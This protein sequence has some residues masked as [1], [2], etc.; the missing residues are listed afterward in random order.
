MGIDESRSKNRSLSR[1]KNRRTSF[2]SLLC[3]QLE[4]REVMAGAIFTPGTDSNYMD[5][6]QS[7]IENFAQQQL[8]GGGNQINL[9]GN[10]WVN[11]TGGAS[12]NDGDPATITWSIVPDGTQVYNSTNGNLGSS[13]FVAFMDGIYGSA[14]GPI[15]SRPW[16]NLVKRGYDNWGANSGLNFIYEPKDD[17]APSIASSRGVL[18]VRGDIRVGGLAVDGNSGIL[19]YA[20]PPY[21]SGNNGI[22]GDI[23]FD[24]NDNFYS[25]NSDGPTGENRAFI[26]VMMHEAGHGVGLGHVL[27]TD[28]TKLME[29]FVSLA[30]Y[31]AQL[32]DIIATQTLYGDNFENNDGNGQASNLGLVGNGVQQFDNLSIDKSEDTDVY[33][34]TVGAA[35]VRRITMIP[36]GKQYQVQPEGGAL[37]TENT[38]VYRNLSF[39]IERL[40]GEV[41]A[42]SDLNP[43]GVPEVINSPSLTAGT[44]YLRVFAKNA[45]ETQMYSLK[46]EADAK[47]SVGPTLI[48]VQPN[49]SEL[50]ENGVVRSIAP[51]ELTFRFDDAQIIDPSTVSGIRVSRAGG[52]GSFSLPS[53]STDFGTNGRV[54]V[55][56]TAKNASDTL[57]INVTRADL[58]AGAPPKITI[59]GNVISLQLNSR[60]GSTVSAQQL[61]DLINAP[62]SPV[63]TK[64]SA[65]INGG[66]PATQLGAADPTTYSPILLQQSNDIIVS[67]GAV[68]VGDSPN[69]NEVT[70]RFAENLPD[71]VYR[72][73]VFGFDDSSR[74][75]TGLRNTSGDLFLPND[76]NTRQDTIEFRLDLGSKVTAVVPQPVVRNTFGVLEQKRDTIVV[77]FDNEKLFVENDASGNPTAGS[78]ENPD[79]YQ[80]LYTADT[81]R[82]TDDITFKPE[83]VTYNASANTATLRFSQD[84]DTLP[85]PFIPSSTFRLRVGTRE[86]T[87]IQ[88]VRSEASASAISDLNTNGLAKVRFQAKT[89]GEAGSGLQVAFVNSNSGGVPTV[90]SVGGIVTVDIGSSSATVGAVVDA[91]QKSTV[92]SPLMSVTLEPGTNP[93]TVVGDRVINYSPVT[94]YGLGSSFSTAADLGTIGSSAVPLTSVLLTSSID[95]EV[96]TLDLIGANNDPGSRKV[97][98]AFENYI[99]PAFTGDNFNGIRTIYYNFQDGY[100][101]VGGVT[102]SNAVTE[103]QKARIREAFSI[104]A[105]NIG[106]QFVE[107]PNSGLTMALGSLNALPSP[108]GLRVENAAS[109]FWGVRIDPTY[110]NSLAVFS[111][112][113]QWDDNYGENM[114]RAAM[115]SIGL[116][117]GLARAGDADPSTLMKFDSNFIN[118]TAGSDRNFE[119][120]F[121]GNLDTMRAQYLH[122]PESSDIDLYR[123]DVDFGTNGENRQGAL[124][125]ESFAE[126]ASSSSPL[127]TRLALFKQTQ[128]TAVSNLGAGGGVEVLFTA[129][130]PGKEG[131]NLQVF[132]TRSNRGVGA[133]PIINTFPNAITIDLNSSIGSETTLNELL[134][135]LDNDPAAR[136][137]VKVTLNKGDRAAVIG[138]RDITYSPITLFGGNVELIAQ[139]DDYFS[140]DSLIRMNLD[141][142]V[143]YIGVSASGNDKYD[144]S[145]PGTGN[146]GRTQGRYD[147]RLTFRA[148]TDG[149]DSIRDVSNGSG[150]PG[151]SLDGDGDG[152][153]G[154]VYNFWFETRPLDR[155]LRFNADGTAPIDGR[156]VTVTGGNGVVR[157]FEFSTDATV[158]IGNTAVRYTA[159]STAGDLALALAAAI[160]SRTELGVSATANGARITLKG[161]RLVQLSSGLTAIDISGKTIFVD[162]SA[163]P[164]ADGSLAKPFNN[165]AGSGVANA[166][167]A[168]LPGDIVRIVGN[169]G[170]DGKIETAN[171][172]F[173]YEV[174]YGVLAGSILADGA[175]MDVPKGVS[176]MVD[177]GAVF[178]MRRS[179]VGIGSSTLGVDRS[180]GAL[181][182]L[183]TP[184]LLDRNGNA[185]R[186]ANG[187]SVS[188]NVFFTSWLDESIGFDNY[189]PTT[190]PAAGDWGGLLFKRDLDK[191]AGRFD[192]EDEGIFRQYVNYAD[193]QYGGSSAVVIDSVQQS[194]NSIQITEMRPTLTFNRISNGA[195]SAISA[196]PDSFEE[197][198]FSDLRYQRKGSFTPDYDRIGPDIHDNTLV[199]NS[200]NG[201]FIKVSTPAGGEL[202]QLTVPGRFNDTDI[203]H[204]I[205]ENIIVQGNPGGAQL[206]A[207]VVSSNLI[208]LAPTLG[209]TFLPGSYSYKLTFVDK[210]GYETPPSNATQSI[211]L[212]PGQTAIRLI[213]LP[214][215]T[216]EYVSRRLYRADSVGGPYRLVAELDSST[217]SYQDR[218]TVLADALD[219]YA[220]LLR[221]R[222]NVSGIT[223]TPTSGGSLAAAAYT[224]RIVMID[225]M[226]R[227]GLASNTTAIATSTAT[228]RSL[229]LNNLPA[230]QAGYAGRRIYRSASGGAGT[231]SLIAEIRDPAINSYLDNGTTTLTGTL[232]VESSGNIRPRLDASLSIDPGS[233]IKIEGARIEFGQSTQLLAEGTDGNRIVFT[234]KQDDR[235]GAG[236]TFDT[237]NNGLRGSLDAKARD[238]SGIYASPG[239][240]ISLDNTVVAYAGGI[241]RLEGTFKAFS[242]LE[243]QQADARV[244]NSVFENNGNG[245]GGQGPIDRL[246]RPANENYPFG[247]N[248]S[249]GAT[250]FI[251]GTQ[252]IFVNNTFQNNVGTALTIDANSMD[253]ELRGDI[254][255][256][257]GEVDRIKNLDANRG[258]L[259]RG[260]RLYNNSINGLEVRADASTNNR[261]E[262]ALAVRDLQRN[263]LTTESVWDDT[264]MVHVL[265]D[266]ITVGNLQSVGGLR[267]QSSVNESL[268]IKMEGQGSN[269][270]QERGTGFTATGRF[271]GIGDRVGGT[272]TVMGMPGFPVVLTS[273]RDDSVGAG[274]Q[275]DGR[276][277]TD[278]N[279]DGIASI[280]RA[281]DWRSMLFDSFSNDRNVQTVLELEQADVIA[282][283]LNDSVLSAQFMGTMAPNA[284]TSDENLRLGFVVHGVLSE[285][286]DQDLFSFVA[287]AGTEVWFD[288]D[289]TEITLD[290]VIEILNANGDL[291]ARSDDS[292][293]EQLNPSLIYRDP[294]LD[295]D[296][297]NPIVQKNRSTARRNESGLLKEDG[298]TNTS[299]AGLRMILPGVTGATSTY[300]FRVRSKS[301]NIENP[302]AGITSGSYS[303]QVRM[304]DEQEFAGSTVQFAE[305]RYSTNGIQVNGLP[306]SSPLTGEANSA[307]YDGVVETGTTPTVTDLGPLQLTNKGAIS[308]AGTLNAGVNRYR[309]TVGDLASTYVGTPSASSTYP[310]VIDVDY[311]DGLNRKRLNVQ[312]LYDDD[313]NA[314][315]PGIPVTGISRSRSLIVDDVPGPLSG[316]DLD[317]LSRGSVGTADPFISFIGTAELRRGTY[318]VIVSDNDIG[319][320]KSGMYQMEI[321]QG[322]KIAGTLPRNYRGSYSTTVEFQAGLTA[323]NMSGKVVS[324]SDGSNRVNLEFTLT[325]NVAFGNIPVVIAAGDSPARLGDKFRDVINQLYLQKQLNVRASDSAGVVNGNGNGIIDLF[326][327]VQVLDPSGAFT[328]SGTSGIQNFDGAGDQNV[329]RDQGQLI[330]S[331]NVITKARDW[332]VWS[333]PADKYYAD[334]RA[335]QARTN[336]FDSTNP[337][338]PP[339]LGG[340]FARNLPV[341][342]EVPFGVAVG[343]VAER[344]GV[345]PGMVVVNNVFDEA[346]LGGLHIQGEEP[347]WRLTVRPGILD[348]S[349]DGATGNHAGSRFD[350]SIPNRL[351]V[352][353]GRQ[354]VRFEFEDIAGAITGGPDFGSGVT[355]GNGWSPDFIPI[356]YRE[357]AGA[358][359]LRPAPTNPGYAADEMV[360]AI[361][362]SFYGSI[363]TT[364]GT[365]QHIYTWF[366]PQNRIVQTDPADPATWIY[367]SATL[368]V[369][370]PQYFDTLGTGTPITITRVGEFTAAPFVRAVNN[371]IV[372]NDG[373]AAFNP[374]SVDLDNNDTLAGA[375]ETYQGVNINPRQY[376]VNGTLSPDPLSTGS[377]D[378]DIYKFQLEIG[379]R[380][381]VN[382]DTGAGSR[383]DA[384]LK[385]FDANGV[386]QIVSTSQDPTTSE[387]NAAPGESAGLDPYIDF[388]ATKAGVYYAAVSAAGNTSYDPLSLADRKRGTTS[389]DYKLILEVLRP[390]QF[391]I[392]VDEVNTYADGETF[393]I[394]QVA[395]FIGTTNNSRTF[396]FTRS[397]AV[398][399][400]N[401]PVYIGN[402]YRVPDLARSIAMAINLA[403]M[404]NVQ[405]LGNGPFGVAS[406]LA[407][408]SAI[409]LGGINGFNPST[410]NLIA[411]D[412]GVNSGNIRGAELEVGL[413][414]VQNSTNDFNPPGPFSPFDAGSGPGGNHMGLGFGHDRTMS[415]GFGTAQGNG[416]TE[417]FVVI[418][419]AYSIN[420]SVTRRINAQVGSNNAN[421]LIPETGI[422]VSGGAT[423]TLLNNAFVNVQS[424]IIQEVAGLR[425][426]AVIVGGNTYQYIEAAKPDS[427]LTWGTIEAVPT[428]VPNTNT[429][430]NFIAGNSEKLLADFPG[431]KFIPASGS[432]IIDSSID[433]MPEREK[434][435]ATKASVG[436]APSPIL[437]P[438]RDYYGLLRA[439]DPS[440]A[441][442]SGLGGNVFKDRGAIDRADFVGP[443]AVSLKPID[444]DAQNV[445]IDKTESVMQLTAGVYP[446]FRIQLKDGFESAN[447]GGGTGINDDS[448]TGRTGGNR[449]PGSVVT[450][451][452]NGRLLVEGMDYAF[453]YNTTTNEIVLKPLAG[454][455]KNDRVYDITINNKDRFVV[456]APAGDQIEDGDIFT[457]RDANG[458]DVTFEY[459]S[460]YRLQLPQGLQLNVPLAGGGA[461]GIVDG[462]RFSLTSG[463]KTVQ[464]E[465]D[466]NA[467]IIDTTATVIKFASLST[468]S[469][470]SDAII[471]A[472]NGA[473]LAGVTA[474]KDSVGNVFIGAPLG[475]YVNTAAAPSV[476]QP[477]QT[478]GLLVPAL[479]TRPG[480]ISDGQTFSLS[481]GRI[482]VVFEFDADA[483]PQVQSGN[484]RI[485]ISN[486]NT[487]AEVATAIKNAIDSSPLAL[488]SL[489]VNNNIVYLGLPE[490]GR[491]D[492][493]SSKLDV[494]GVARTILDGQ[495]ITITRTVGSLVIA[496]TF[497]F[498]TD[499]NVATGNIA[500]PFTLSS[501]Q[502]EIGDTLAAAI[503]NAGLGLAPAHVGNGNVII[504][505]SPE[506]SVSVANAPTVGVFGQ[507]GVQGNST[508]QIF[509]T[510]QLMVPSRGGADLKD[511]TTFTITSGS[512]TAT[513]EFDGN[514]SG[515]T[516]PGSSTIRFTPASTQS[517]IVTLIVQAIN[518]KTALGI[519]ARD[520]GLG[521]I[522]LGL[523]ENSAVNVRDSKLTTDRGNVQDGDY[524]TISNGTTAVTFEFE[525]LSLGNGYNPSRTPIRFT[526]GD[527][528]QRVYEA[529]QATIKSSALKLDTDITSDGLRLRDNA[530]FLINT[531]N[532]PSLRKLGVPGGAIA[533]PFVQ[534]A[535]FTSEQVRDSIIRAIN[536][537]T[538]AGKTPLVAKVRGGSTLFVENAISI[539]SD[540]NSFYLRGVQDNAGNFLKSNRITNE[541]QFTIIMPGVE[542]DFGDAPDPFST[543]LGRYP[544]LKANDGARHVMT[545]IG[546]RLGTVI[547]AE[548]D[549]Q[550]QPLGDGDI[551]DDGVSFQ[552][553]TNVYTLNDSPLFNK[554]VDTAITVSMTAPGVLNAWI[555]FNA[556][557][558]WE[559]PGEN[560]LTDAVFNAVTLQQTF[561]VRI[562]ATSPTPTTATPAFAR[563]RAS[564]LGTKLPTG[565]ALDGEVEDYRVIIAPGTP[566]TGVNDAYSMNEDQPGGLSTTDALGTV[567]PGFGVDDG[568]L[569]NDI[570]PDNKSL[571]ASL[572][573]PPKYA[574]SF[575]FRPDG[576]FDYAP[577]ADFFGTD[578]FVYK[579]NDGVLDSLNYATA[580]I[581]VRPVNDAPI[582]GNLSYTI[583]ED[584]V[585]EVAESA[586]IAVS[587]PGP[588][589]ESDQIIKIQSVDALSNKG[590][591]VRFIG[592]KITYQPLP[593][594]SG[595]DYFTYTIIDNGVTGVL[596]DP[597]TAVGTIFLTVKDKNDAPITT[598]KTLNTIEDT[599]AS[600]SI[601]DLIFGDVVGP[602]DEQ[603]SQVLNFTGVN[604]PS[605]KG[606]TVIVVGDRVVYTPP[607][608]YNG[609]DTFTYIVTDNGV[610]DGQPDPQ[611]AL[612]TVTVNI[613]ARNDAPEVVKPFGTVSMKED[614]DEIAL[615]LSDYFT[616]PDI[617]L[618]GDVLTYTVIS[619]TN[620]GLIE[621]TFGNGNVYLKPKADQNG[622][623]TIVI[624]AM[625]KAGL[626]VTNTMKVVVTPVDDDPRLVTP[627]PDLS[628]SEDSPPLNIVLTPTYF[629][630]PDVI[631]GDKLSFEATSS[632]TDI[633]E[634][635]ISGDS[636]L[637]TLV[638]NANGQTT[639][640]V[641]ATDL[642]GRSVSDSF[643]LTVT[644]VNDGPITVPDSYTTPQGVTLITTDARGTLTVTTTDD[645]VLANDKDPEGDSFTATVTVQPTRGSVTM[646]ADGTF[647]YIP[648]STALAGTTD[649]FKYVAKDSQGA[650]SVA[651]TVTITIGR[652]PQPKYQ[653]PTRKQDVNAD[654]FISPI[655]VLIVVNLLNSRGP[656][657]PVEGLPGPPDYV[658]VNGDNVVNP[659]DALEVINYINSQSGGSSGGEGEGFSSVQQV[660]APWSQGWNVDIGRGVENTTVAMSAVQSLMP[661]VTRSS[662]NSTGSMAPSPSAP[663]NLSSLNI[664]EDELDTLADDLSRYGARDNDSIV[665]Q[666]LS[667]L[668]GE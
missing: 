390:E 486:A 216:G 245:M 317:D 167:S 528:R 488:D 264:D 493:V 13:N 116:M 517:D 471:A 499:S 144:A 299:D 518:A 594:F 491:V 14:A 255:R 348:S 335:Q 625:D 627:L 286:A 66:L 582:A 657:V 73:E 225:S 509:G 435:R 111:A 513:F 135:A 294:A 587:S 188:G 307:M 659:L 340:A 49:N 114:T 433:S 638:P 494:V 412:L 244:A 438:D 36:T 237:N 635:R 273:L 278:T 26:N 639:I 378:V 354:R 150:D 218:G 90:S 175:T 95:A 512:I 578:T 260:N 401:I 270:D 463:S 341:A 133:K 162:K 550:P 112:D 485:D 583:L 393:T 652:P 487:D 224:Y 215:T 417:K 316:S 501:T 382:V 478:T 664:E 424:P 165:I 205:T 234:S 411:P 252:P 574:Q 87:P 29:P 554:N 302:A 134:T 118:F 261:N 540:V 22:D 526:N 327:K 399:A 185:V 231:F 322:D 269:F 108:G 668:F 6:V 84:I 328:V 370:G 79:F 187:Q 567:T 615:P 68:I 88:P 331:N 229:R 566:P 444:N 632:N 16:F 515:S 628:V 418:R 301:T 552:F 192:L 100:G 145:V 263:L 462:D 474:R 519:T 136:S 169:G 450:I 109:G 126:R 598:P 436:I 143:Y 551:G 104:W 212:L 449:L 93:N 656:S 98:E 434:Y 124:T 484:I 586:V 651:T 132:V 161:E 67:P 160:N 545:D 325:G 489:V 548:R 584:Q 330:I 557:G 422:M 147:L 564:T 45:G 164:N 310:V 279:N 536:A 408:V 666:A 525:N 503:K 506:Y 213:G 271:G 105:D 52:D 556:D 344:A 228:N 415:G 33:L 470:V 139:N 78:A 414:R 17:G 174:G 304:R 146:G 138:D 282:P 89:L 458:G 624:Q 256:Q 347:T 588:A 533:V 662:S 546:P 221:D 39:Q 131:N 661:M 275:P 402:E 663:W 243:L 123:F 613:E 392:T 353:F 645:G 468:K 633:A 451:T 3:E 527:S 475:T 358:V 242:P 47:T 129:V 220:T 137:L 62:S 324:V 467:N 250:V 204:V 373:R 295:A 368:I 267:L 405:T 99:N 60:S 170:A 10:R 8:G 508:L 274:T 558:D 246:G 53:V 559:D 391:V 48:G 604:S 581:T 653:N 426:A 420:S 416:T 122:R 591:S 168:A 453:S 608:N 579:V 626:T 332:A 654:G 82:N 15:S 20:F 473:S 636:L 511:D 621:P 660:V 547:T 541:T 469:E 24:T 400:G 313:N 359:Y 154:G 349:F 419:N 542:L 560:I 641:K 423:P 259:F 466:N 363:L 186:G 576:T 601:A 272:V 555:D 314:N 159:S 181:Q 520:A 593:N 44:Y 189:Q 442:P 648:G 361:R 524:F 464:F 214:G 589:N 107:T 277:Q 289:S 199:N 285:P 600:I 232:S 333:A 320:T 630:D 91:L 266:S 603:G 413:N 338:A 650:A 1:L 535:S 37:T 103:K 296:Q 23:V 539:S 326:G 309:F 480:G 72:L 230:V 602:A 251:R 623:A 81:V 219:P 156:I 288:V 575:N 206:D 372:G 345:A 306:S 481:D 532:A 569:A 32:D 643:V 276:P 440:V 239:A 398:S 500:I 655:D 183:G 337:V 386:A 184:K 522:D 96:H 58:G 158:G 649:T 531:D 631:N 284:Q 163:G 321:R 292:T 74:G 385:I 383:L 297:V 268:V 46:M 227:E 634:V 153:P 529:M 19:A 374:V 497:E 191:S 248:N 34:L 432:Q 7:R 502:S 329:V 202:K 406:P 318:E 323:A 357:D 516:V 5:Q 427:N 365:T 69:E 369:R 565:L 43:A 387:N 76:P 157:R 57:Q 658:D 283:G 629:F 619:N 9:L 563:F 597:L 428:N 492:V 599:P 507:P 521:R 166:F 544:T 549:G 83:K 148:Q 592:G 452:E 40:N 56:L 534:D 223:I 606:G 404:G 30:Y 429:D 293:A 388:T 580:V 457:I 211:D 41:V 226:G 115:A 141:S 350:D 351:E 12:P 298:T 300:F 617:I 121:P 210:N 573:T 195:D 454:V 280:P 538:A 612:G 209:G 241:S 61:V 642:T 312:V 460:G 504:G 217:T 482:A 262:D 80:L 346:G 441:P 384:A 179:R 479:G 572:I 176:V 110:Q 514:F 614:A 11:P 173:A 149:V 495:S 355:G 376:T 620:T 113:N 59:T 196:T 92:S 562:P 590:G 190:T 238:W 236:G 258:P 490:T 421:Q 336:A 120:V 446:E 334:G 622:Q 407:P 25:Q 77:Y 616:D 63:A 362:D 308:V 379:E 397:G 290:T 140:K 222:P 443:Y 456:N 637:I 198:L 102:Q 21:G 595:S 640:F 343:S 618:N 496:K 395:D 459:D 125:I 647:T 142:G 64:L 50:I 305:I 510:L 31:G 35:R 667:D 155:V 364:N 71:D 530:S 303:V 396:E 596:A 86:S 177:A 178:K 455:W 201:L 375:A 315:T 352:G 445:D 431:N 106:V 360:K 265:F 505:G 437:A 543:T 257:S 194:V 208:S 498:T 477:K 27:P 585:L 38:L 2:R 254:G 247:N 577:V 180:G 537:A 570:N 101:S 409:A 571:T 233:I 371:T 339:T 151:V 240:N 197:T 447:L 207:T 342:N 607:K 425:P 42:A 553:Q 523:L 193:I 366:E 461:G 483:Q 319:S 130:K 249:R 367:P 55:Q 51:R 54:D 644:P 94:L 4:R 65:K 465:F 410:G 472:I 119:P 117:L 253:A 448:V 281:G 561:N 171:D 403:G 70:L 476:T 439:D 389:G 568:V 609:V 128:A 152:V 430:F 605:A 127:D 18:G 377:S 311:A 85:G 235:F 394:S 380:V 200:I 665:D 611:S 381:R 646:N 291:I 182:V 172:N 75:I 97:P 356:Y 203:V 28:Q 610:S 287:T